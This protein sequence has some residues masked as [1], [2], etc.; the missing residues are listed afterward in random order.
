V[1][2]FCGEK[3]LNLKMNGADTTL[4]TASNSDF[5]YFSAPADTTNF[6]SQ[7]ASVE[8]SMKDYP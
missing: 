1:P 2:D 7:L 6:G 8:V 3:L 4:I 5:I